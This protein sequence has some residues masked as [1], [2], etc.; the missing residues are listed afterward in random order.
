MQ[1]VARPHLCWDEHLCGTFTRRTA[2]WLDPRPESERGR[3]DLQ[4]I[5]VAQGS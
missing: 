5:R 4:A 1:G 2:L 3:G